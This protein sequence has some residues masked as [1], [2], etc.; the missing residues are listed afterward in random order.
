[1]KNVILT[2]GRECGSGGK[3]IGQRVAKKLNIPFYDKELIN[4]AHESSKYNY[5]KIN[6]HDEIKRNSSLRPVDY[7]QTGDYNEIFSDD[8]YQSLINKTILEISSSSCVILGRNSNNILKGKPNV[9]NIFI[10]SNN[11]DFKITRKMNIEKI[12]YE[13]TRKKLKTID[14]QRK[15]YYESLNKNKTW[16][17]IREYDYCIDSSILGIDKTIDLIVDIYN[18]Y[19]NQ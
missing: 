15:K 5:S 14:N 7:I 19:K 6:E 10:Y 11:M 12:S 16:G 13:E 9:I 17:S 18:S 1:M 4:K 3:Y 8:I 2:I